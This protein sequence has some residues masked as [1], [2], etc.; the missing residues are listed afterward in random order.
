MAKKKKLNAKQKRE[1]RE[2]ER[3]DRKLYEEGKKKA[4][5]PKST[6]ARQKAREE[7][8]Q[9]QI[10]EHRKQH[11]T[12]RDV[13]KMEKQTLKAHLYG[14][15]MQAWTKYMNLIQMGIKNAATAIYET[16][17]LGQ[18]NDLDNMD[19]NT[20]RALLKVVD[21][22][23]SRKDINKKRAKKN[24][25]KAKKEY[26]FES[27]DD[28]SN[29]WEKFKKWMESS[30]AAKGTVGS[31]KKIQ[32]FKDAYQK[33]KA[34]GS[35]DMQELFDLADRELRDNYDPIDSFDY[36]GEDEYE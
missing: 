12:Q 25:E 1:R 30:D 34:S 10:E 28:A 35:D 22:W 2:R 8:R 32:A 17:L 5:G 20:L 29:F 24:W 19:I 16:D 7:L 4:S 21:K 3:L 31:P 14:K 6:R 36:P 33:W 18:I 26:G 9:Q 27:A 15:L 11:P 13:A 23:L